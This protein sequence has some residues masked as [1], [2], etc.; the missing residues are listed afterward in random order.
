MRVNK[1]YIL[2]IV[3]VVGAA[4]FFWVQRERSNAAAREGTRIIHLKKGTIETFISTTGTVLPKNRLEIRPPVNG[5]VEQVLVKEGDMVKTGQI[6]AWMSS[7]DRA[8]L[9]DAARGKS[10]ESLA[11]WNDVYK[12]IALVAPINGQVIVATM[13]PGQTVTTADA[14][15][16]LSDKLIF[17]AQVDETDIGKIS[18][19]QEAVA[20]LDAYQDTKID[21][22]VEHV[23]YESKTVNNVTI[24]DVDLKADELPAF[25]RSGMNV[26]VDFRSQYKENIFTLPV[27]AVHKD[28]DGSFVL[29]KVPETSQPVR[30]AVVVGITDDAVVEIVS[31]VTADDQ[32]VVQRKKFTLSKGTTGTNPFAPARPAG[33]GQGGA[34]R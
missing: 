24:Y 1:F 28:K 8:A 32:I 10:D 6:V 15:I 9:L 33:G 4:G 20:T 11:Y 18:E 17:R 31:G 27:D 26:S 12:P 7:T 2:G 34:R 25:C 21:S 14:V 22:E 5:R 16:V 30:H 23:Y 19:G 13:Q 3:L 29:L